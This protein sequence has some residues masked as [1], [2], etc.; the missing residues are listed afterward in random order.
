MLR[1]ALALALTAVLALPAAAS[2]TVRV[3]DLDGIPRITLEGNWVGSRYTIH[4][5]GATGLDLRT[6]TETNTLCTGDCFVVDHQA[7]PG[8]TY[9]YTFDL[10]LPDGS[11]R[12]YGPFDVV[13][14]GRPATRLQAMATPNPLR[15]R[16]TLRIEA[17]LAAG[18]RAADASEPM[19]LP[20]EAVLL[21]PAGRV[22]RTLWRGTLDRLFVD[23]P[24]EAR[25][26][27]GARLAPG[28]YF[29]RMRAGDH[30]GVSRLTIVR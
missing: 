10:L 11:Q 12:R 30:Q 21:D 14:G 23:V 25:D 16:G 22:L 7:I 28:T 26:A 29:V 5:A 2:P 19:R 4:R 27:R 3:D 8:A 9:Q 18:A 1:T 17:G 15:E 20:G 6:V 13:I 24:F